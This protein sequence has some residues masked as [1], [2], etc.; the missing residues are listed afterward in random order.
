MELKVS[1]NGILMV[2]DGYIMFKNFAGKMTAYNAEGNRN[3]ALSIPT[4][5]M[6]DALVRDGW[7]VK[8]RDGVNP[9]DEPRMHLPVKVKFGYSAGPNI[10]LTSG[11]NRRQLTEDEVEILDRINIA[12]VDLD[13]RPYD[14]VTQKGTK[15]EKRGR[16]AYLQNM[17]VEQNIDRFAQ[18]F[19]EEEAPDDEDELPFK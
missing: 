7:N 18:R 4:R 16:T 2:D 12:R 17:Y 15:N 5:E 11:K 1:E 6:A 3:F 13:I 10:Y 14:W 9:G 19:A 8:I